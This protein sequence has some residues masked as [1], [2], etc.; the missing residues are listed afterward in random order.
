MEGVIVDCLEDIM[1]ELYSLD[2]NHWS[3]NVSRILS[4]LSLQYRIN[5]VCSGEEFLYDQFL[6]VHALNRAERETL[7]GCLGI[8]SYLTTGHLKKI[9]IFAV[10]IDSQESLRNDLAF[11]LTRLFGKMFGKRLVLIVVNKD[12]LTF[13]GIEPHKKSEEV[14]LSDW[15]CYSKD[16]TVN[17]RIL[18]IDFS[19]FHTY[20]DYLWAI[21]RPY[22][23]YSESKMYLIFE[24]YSPIQYRMAGNRVD[25][26]F[27][28]YLDIGRDEE[29]EINSQYYPNIYGQD[30][31]LDDS[32]SKI[33]ENLEN[34]DDPEFEWT[35][36]EMQ[37]DED[38]GEE[39]DYDFSDEDDFDMEESPS[40]NFRLS[41][42]N[43]E[44]ML[45]YI[46]R[47]NK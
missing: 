39:E 36:L 17:E 19:L 45:S 31:F 26:Y 32:E 5:Y 7:K 29:L 21:A 13:T 28:E 3:E 23:K 43:P 40:T 47:D 42:M 11:E 25:S 10:L 27:P 6:G 12:S 24:C 41:H 20:G 4:L 33:D 9:K 46:R 38:L 15:F 8:I 2:S 30:Y 14:L 35:M 16:Q 1:S 34:E 18:E 37:L 44:E 22:K